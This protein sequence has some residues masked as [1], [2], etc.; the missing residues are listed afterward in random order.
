VT[1]VDTNILV[2]ST[3]AAAPFHVRARA[4][5]GTLAAEAPLSLSRQILRE[6]LSVMTRP[7]PWGKALSLSEAT[8]DTA[9]FL[10]RFS[11]LED[12]PMV[13]DALLDLCRRFT[14]GGRQVHDANIVATMLAHGERRLLTFNDA[15]FRR[16]A[17]VID[18]VVP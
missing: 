6:Y 11:L 1:F 17:S 3:A 18:I 12:G 15:D 10:Q 9:F 14:F 13:W 8:A 7:Q 5:L 16:F 2:Y 4:A